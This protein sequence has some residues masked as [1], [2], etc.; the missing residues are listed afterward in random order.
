MG[1]GAGMEAF[2]EQSVVLVLLAFVAGLGS[3]GLVVGL[4]S[5]ARRDRWRSSL[6]GRRPDAPASGPPAVGAHLPEPLLAAAPA[7]E[8]LDVPRTRREARTRR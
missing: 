2:V 8:L 1:R 3:A 4:T 7:F 6:A 5:R